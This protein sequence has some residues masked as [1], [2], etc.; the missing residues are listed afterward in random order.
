MPDVGSRDGTAGSRATV[1][2]VVCTRDRPVLLERCLGAVTRQTLLP[3]EIRIVDNS[4]GDARV[5]TVAERFGATYQVAPRIGLSRA[6]NAGAR[7]AKTDILC[8]TDD[9][10][11]PEPT[12]LKGLVAEFSDPSVGAACGAVDPLTVETDAEKWMASLEAWA[13]LKR[14]RRRVTSADPDWFGLANFGGLGDG[15]NLALR[16]SVFERWAGFDERLGRGA[17]MRGG[18]D[19]F[20]LFELIERGFTVVYTPDAV[21]RHPYPESMEE[22]RRDLADRRTDVAAYATFLFFERP[23]HRGDL[24]R[25]VVGHV[26]GTRCSW[27]VDAKGPRP[28]ILSALR[29]A[30]CGVMGSWR[31][32]GCAVES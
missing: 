3:D 27:R 2:V 7:A 13:G 14:E 16:R 12:W 20:A 23:R 24:V 25:F 9:D 5:R 8:Y 29:R 19:H 26:R 6:R 18:E 17:R 21:V 4:S 11:V 15:N 1:S 32:L 22:L 10:A 31:Y 30:S 28:R